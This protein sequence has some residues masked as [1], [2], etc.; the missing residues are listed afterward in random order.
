MINQ[1]NSI[2]S[3]EIVGFGDDPVYLANYGVMTNR[4]GS[5]SVNAATFRKAYEANL[6]EFN[7]ILNSRVTTGSSLVSGSLLAAPDTHRGSYAFTYRVAPP[8]STAMR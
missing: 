1:I 4:D 8:R 5:I 3:E 2:T 6:D 7:A